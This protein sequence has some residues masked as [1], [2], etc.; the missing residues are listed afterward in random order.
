MLWPLLLLSPNS[1]IN[2][3]SNKCRQNVG[4]FFFRSQQ[5]IYEC[6]NNE[7]GKDDNSRHKMYKKI[8]T[9]FTS[10]WKA[11]P[12]VLRDKIGR[13]AGAEV[14]LPC[15]QEMSSGCGSKRNDFRRKLTGGFEKKEV[16]DAFWGHGIILELI[17]VS[18]VF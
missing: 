7:R 17:H 4:R 9:T 14:K 10:H 6:V 16:Y 5:R 18:V 12:L 8:P 1:T 3:I 11:K 2:L 13:R 15:D